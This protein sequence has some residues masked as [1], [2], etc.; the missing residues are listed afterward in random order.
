MFIKYEKPCI[1]YWTAAELNKIEAQMS[2][3]IGRCGTEPA[4]GKTE[5]HQDVAVSYTGAVWTPDNDM[6]FAGLKTVS[7][8]WYVPKDKVPVMLQALRDSNTER[9]DEIKKAIRRGEYA[10]LDI[11]SVKEILKL[12]GSKGIMTAAVIMLGLFELD[13]KMIKKLSSQVIDVTGYQFEKGIVVKKSIDIV[14][15]AY[16]QVEEWREEAQ[17]I[18][19]GEKGVYGKFTEL[20]EFK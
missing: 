15:Q 14:R 3:G 16:W 12:Q 17:G 1:R 4:D 9:N 5:K 19:R 8:L 6:R 13:S 2:C 18:V 7:A 10:A 20:T 11:L